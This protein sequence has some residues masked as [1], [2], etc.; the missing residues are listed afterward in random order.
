MRHRGAVL[1]MAA[2]LWK[3]DGRGPAGLRRRQEE[4]LASLVSH[5]K[6]G[7]LGA[8]MSAPR[9]AILHTIALRTEV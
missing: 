1:G 9:C 6:S 3:A 4:R 5:A 8:P 7:A 2:D